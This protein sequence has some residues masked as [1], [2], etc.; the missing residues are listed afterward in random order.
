MRGFT[1]VEL[2]IY[3]AIFAFLAVGF[4]SFSIALSNVKAKALVS[5]EVQS[6]GRVALGL[7][8][9]RIKSANGVNLGTSAFGVDPGVLSLSMASSTLNP[10]IIDL[11]QNDGRVRIK[12]GLQPSVF[13]TSDSVKVTNFMFTNLSSLS[14]RENIRVEM[15]IEYDNPSGDVEYQFSQNLRSAASLRN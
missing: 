7:I 1:L 4:V 6:N 15:N 14:S 8:T 13:V 11:D 9:Q 10:T 5:S 12:E 3:I 2:L